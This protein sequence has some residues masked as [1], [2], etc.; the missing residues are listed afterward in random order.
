MQWIIVVIG[1][2]FSVIGAFIANWILIF[3]I[4]PI[5]LI[6]AIALFIIG[7]ISY[8]EYDNLFEYGIIFGI[9]LVASFVGII[10]L[11]VFYWDS[12]IVPCLIRSIPIYT[13]EITNYLLNPESSKL[14]PAICI[15]IAEPIIIAIMVPFFFEGIHISGVYIVEFVNKIRE[16][17]F[18]RKYFNV[19]LRFIYGHR[20]VSDKEIVKYI[21]CENKSI[22]LKNALLDNLKK[23][24]A[25]ILIIYIHCTGAEKHL[26]T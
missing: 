13:E 26:K 12:I 19:C 23:V 10:C 4:H 6:L 15:T 9:S 25:Y 22:N 17:I 1:I 5:L 3:S 7:I 11:E 14:L 16:K 20:P 24:K 21:H 2:L 8:K 18:K